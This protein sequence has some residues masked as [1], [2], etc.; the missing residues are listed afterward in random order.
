M[1]A[2]TSTKSTTSTEKRSTTIKPVNDYILIEV[3]QSAKE[4]E[5][6]IILT[7]EERPKQTATII[8][9]GNKVESDVK[10]GDRIIFSNMAGLIIELG[11]AKLTFIQD[12]DLIAVLD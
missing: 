4:T 3:D 12:C 1:P 2:S 11:G 7:R 9:V 8:E 5:H 6:G 10:P